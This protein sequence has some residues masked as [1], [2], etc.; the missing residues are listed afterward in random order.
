LLPSCDGAA[1]SA[2]AGGGVSWNVHKWYVAAL[3]RHALTDRLAGDA[4]PAQQSR[5]LTDD[6]TGEQRACC[7]CAKVLLSA[8]ATDAPGAVVSHQQQQRKASC[9]TV[10]QSNTAR[11]A[12]ARMPLS[13]HTHTH[14]LLK[15]SS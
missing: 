6:Q 7:T 13:A 15:C 14:R 2:A 3:C 9:N 5:A 4:A 8:A 10:T 12:N 11:M 1:H